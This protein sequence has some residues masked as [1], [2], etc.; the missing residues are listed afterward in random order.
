M[1]VSPS[2]YKTEEMNASLVLCLLSLSDFLLI[3]VCDP[4][5]DRIRKL[6]AMHFKLTSGR[7]YYVLGNGECY[8]APDF[9]YTPTIKQKGKIGVLSMETELKPGH[10]AFL[11]GFKRATTFR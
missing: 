10:R 3:F 2:F 9:K 7:T 4:S 8:E 11:A 6:H 1:G 5:D